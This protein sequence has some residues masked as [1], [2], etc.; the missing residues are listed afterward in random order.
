MLAKIKFFLWK[1]LEIH[2][3]SQRLWGVLLLS[4][5]TLSRVDI[6]SGWRKTRCCIPF[7]EILCCSEFPGSS[8]FPT[9]IGSSPHLCR[10]LRLRAP[11]GRCCLFTLASSWTQTTQASVISPLGCEITMG[12]SIGK[13]HKDW[14]R[15]AL[16]LA[17]LHCLNLI[18]SLSFWGT[19][20][21]QWDGKFLKQCLPL[22]V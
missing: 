6:L 2:M 19:W 16:L 1:I 20:D 9:G 8:V 4:I 7:S 10:G 18:A 3:G 14:S 11:P 5:W 13:N 17:L 21:A 15:T 22:D 12:R